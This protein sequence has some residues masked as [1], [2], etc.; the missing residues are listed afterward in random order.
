MSSDDVETL[1]DEVAELRDRVSRLEAKIEEN[2]DAFE[3]ATDLRSFV[4]EFD[5]DTHVERAVA[6]AFYIEHYENQES[7]TT[8]DIEDGYERARIQ[9]PANMSD[10]LG[11]CED[12]GWMMRTGR[13]GQAQLRQLT[14]EGIAH[15]EEVLDNGA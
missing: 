12:R 4:A 9:G 6:I 2:P 10:V 7:F 1:R 5:P 11:E 14:A 8:T 13:Q 15:V 3:E